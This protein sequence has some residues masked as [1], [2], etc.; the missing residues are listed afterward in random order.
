MKNGRQILE[1]INT[2]VKPIDYPLAVKMIKKGDEI[3]AS[4]KKPLEDLGTPVALC[5]AYALGRKEG[6][7]LLL[8]KNSQHCPIALAGL[9]FVKPDLFLTGEDV[10]AP[11]NQSVAARKKR[12]GEMPRF[13][14]GTYEGILIAPLSSADF[15]PDVVLMYGSSAQVMRMIQAAVFSDGASLTSASSGSGGC[16]LPIAGTMR[17]D[18]CKYSIPGNGERRLGLVADHEMVFGMPRCCFDDV[19]EGLKLSHDGKQNF[20]ISPGYLKSEYKMPP[21]YNALRQAL[22]ESST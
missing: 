10:L 16:L 9:G 11:V 7:T 6:L 1:A 4:A 5:Q 2:Y 3:P 14:Y 13:E 22:L 17:T 18:E 19:V 15:D 8:D 12:A 20:P 21:K